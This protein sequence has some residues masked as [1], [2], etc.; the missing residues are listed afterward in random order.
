MRKLSFT[1]L[2]SISFLLTADPGRVL[3]APQSD[4]SA[5]AGRLPVRRVVL[6]KNGVG[7]FEHT[8]KV[9]GNQELNIDF[10]TSQLNDVLNS[11]TVVD[12]GQGRIA[13]VRFNSV[14]ELSERMKTLR[15]PLGVETSRTDYLNALRGTRVE[16]SGPGGSGTGRVLTVD[17]RKVLNAKGDDLTEVLELSIITGNGELH[18]F[19]V[20]PA[21]TVRVADPDLSEEVSRYLNLIASAKAMDVRRMTISAAGDGE[22]D[23]FVSYISEVPVWK[24]TYRILLPEKADEKPLIQ[25]W[26][27]VD[28]TVGEDW[29]DVRLSLVAGAPQSFIQP[30]S[31]PYYAPRP[32]V[33]MPESMTLTPQTHEAAEMALGGVTGGVPG[34]VPAPPPPPPPGVGSGSGGGMGVGGGIAGGVYTGGSGLQGVVTDPTGAVISN[35]KVTLTNPATG[36]VRATRTDSQ[37]HYHFARV[38]PGNSTLSFE[39][40][41]FSPLRFTNVHAGRIINATLPVGSV[42]QTVEVNAEAV[43]APE[44]EQKS[45]ITGENRLSLSEAMEA[46]GSEAEGKEISQLFEYD[47]KQ[48]V[49]IEKNQSALVPIVQAHVDG[50]KVTL[51]NAHS[52]GA[53]RALWITNTSGETL[54]GGS[55]SILE[56]DAFAGQ[57]LLDAVQP[58]E[59]RLLS[60]AGDPAVQVKVEGSAS[61]KPISTIIINKGIMF[62]TREERE[63]KT[64]KVSNSDVTARDV[65]IEHPARGGWTLASNLKPEESSASFYRF[66][67][68]VDAKASAQLTVEEYQPQT[69]EFALT[70]LT[71]DYVMI[72]TKQQRV[73]PAMEQVFRRVLDQKSVI[74]GLD[75]QIQVR[76]HE[77]DAIGTDQ[78]RI[79]ENMKALKGS[80][81]ERTLTERYARQLNDQEDRLAALHNQVSDLTKKRQQAQDQLDAI[82]DEITLTEAFRSE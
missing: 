82:L 37:G 48:S 21:T 36:A 3:A 68:K 33:A 67:L 38:Q 29:K 6:Y 24:S 31:Q 28:N 79:R 7:Y 50:E 41:G 27:I 46:A 13:G 47:L 2:V 26:A 17:T 4:A 32:V 44:A 5:P 35:A 8:A 56:S 60:Y 12:L 51:W 53:L 40:P 65:V 66:K 16:V 10:T 76:Q 75:S 58:G 23:V 78:A 57:G 72:L 81:E 62:I 45:L 34:A 11:L 80:A 42:T 22:R 25:G 70:N 55:F 73:T 1:V 74:V 19:E 63:M 54:D 9:R 20:G 52:A 18:T 71:S 59:R 43:G 30:I 64:Y 61:E 15:L 49:T 77:I 14:A 69:T 39:S